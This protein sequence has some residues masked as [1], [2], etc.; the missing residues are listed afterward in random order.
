MAQYEDG[1]TRLACTR[2]V[3]RGRICTMMASLYDNC[4]VRQ[5]GH[6]CTRM[7]QHKNIHKDGLVQN[8]P[9]TRAS[10]NNK[11]RIQGTHNNQNIKKAGGIHNLEAIRSLVSLLTTTMVCPVNC[12]TVL[13]LWRVDSAQ[14]AEHIVQSEFLGEVSPSILWQVMMLSASCF[15]DVAS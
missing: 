14:N 10:Y 15:G 6:H 12:R 9:R 13:G 5:Q 8:F 3:A 4:L 2:I 11:S 1:C 7:A